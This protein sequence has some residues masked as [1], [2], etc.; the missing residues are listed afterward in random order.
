M[1]QLLY[2][3]SIIELRC[4]RNCSRYSISLSSIVLYHIALHGTAMYCN[5]LYCILVYYFAIA[6]YLLYYIILYFIVLQCTALHCI[7]WCCREEFW[8]Q[9]Q[10][11]AAD[12][13]SS[14]GSFVVVTRAFKVVLYLL[15]FLLV[16]GGLLA[17]RVAL[18]AIASGIGRYQ[19]VLANL[20]GDGGDV[21][22]DSNDSVP[23]VITPEVISTC[24]IL[25]QL[26]V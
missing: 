25:L 14:A 2:C 16:L 23:V 12:T 4:N 7:V 26:E 9:F 3:I 24:I 17:S 8:D 11:I 6:F 15:L 13:E 10:S 20:T 22:I 5:A 19:Q 21:S 18:L 1:L